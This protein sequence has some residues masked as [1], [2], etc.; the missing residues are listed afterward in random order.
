MIADS[1][2]TSDASPLVERVRGA[3]AAAPAGMTASIGVVSTPLSPLVARP[4]QDLL[5]KIVGIA[6]E[7]MREARLAG[8]NQARYVLDPDLQLTDEPDPN[9]DPEPDWTI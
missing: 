2:T 7:A 9:A 6:T 3:I 4:P 8:G 5:D 1:F